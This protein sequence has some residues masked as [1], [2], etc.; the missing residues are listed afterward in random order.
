LFVFTI[1]EL[2]L[3]AEVKISMSFQINSLDKLHKESVN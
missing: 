3:S 2:H 1:L